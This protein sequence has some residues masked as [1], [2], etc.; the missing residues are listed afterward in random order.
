LST[1][2]TPGAAGVVFGEATP[3]PEALVHPFR[4]WVTV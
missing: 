4:V 3:E 1:T 2:V